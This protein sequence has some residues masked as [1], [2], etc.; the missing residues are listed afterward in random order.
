MSSLRNQQNRIFLSNKIKKQQLYKEP[1]IDLSKYILEDFNIIILVPYLI[2]SIAEN[3]K[4]IIE[5]LNINVIIHYSTDNIINNPDK[6][7]YIVI[8]ATYLFNNLPK[9]YILYQ[10][11]QINSPFFTEEYYKILENS[12]NIWD[13]SIHN[14]HKYP[15]IP[16]NKIFYCPMP[17]QIID[18]NNYNETEYDL[19]F[20][21][22]YN[23]RREN[24]LN[25]LQQK[26][27]IIIG[28]MFKDDIRDN[29][30]KKSKIIINLHFYDN[31]ALESCRINEVLK[32]NKP[33]ISEYTTKGDWYNMYIYKDVVSFCDIIKDDLSNI[34]CLYDK[35]DYLLNNYNT[36]LETINKERLNIM[37]LTEYFVKKNLL[38]VVD[39]NPFIEYNVCDNNIY[40]LHLLE[41]PLRL[42]AFYKQEYCPK[43]NIYPAY[44]YNP[45]YT[46]CGLSYKNIIWNANRL[47]LNMITICEDDC[48]F[49]TDFENKYSIIQD[50][51]QQTDKWD[52]F[53]GIIA[54]L[55]EDTNIINIYNYKGLVF[56][57]IDRM[58]SMVFNIYNKSSFDTII[59]WDNKIKDP[60]FNQIDQYIK[61]TNLRIITTYP[62]EFDCI[63]VFST[64]WRGN[65]LDQYNEYKKSF[66]NSLILLKIKIDKFNQVKN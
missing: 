49:N 48:K 26:Y 22:S 13:F 62:F 35:I 12:T 60:K 50:F 18:I 51:L 55:P 23:K 16:L 33:I 28:Y 42:E 38:N 30:I 64:L 61:R 17:L 47:N 45:G 63:K 65:N 7:L 1:Y 9:K 34:N 5:K 32:Y 39:I 14:I 40:C 3:L 41:T 59:N 66:Q 44:K 19:F 20:Y 36:M 10:V 58:H 15:N 56:V 46:G 21:G 52:I 29:Y 43:I 25:L 11:E 37:N 24:I 53:V 6:I 4:L 54:S 27:N 8:G 2:R 57:E 31:I